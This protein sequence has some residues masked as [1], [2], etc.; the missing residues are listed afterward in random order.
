[1]RDKQDKR[2]RAAKKKK[3]IKPENEF[4]VFQAHG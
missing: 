4:T 2:W 3:K 1:M